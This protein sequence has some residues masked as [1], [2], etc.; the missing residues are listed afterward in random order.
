[1][2]LTPEQH[3]LVEENYPLAKYLARLVWVK[4]QDR[5]DKDELQSIAFQGLVAAAQKF[6]GSRMSQET[7]DNGKA[8]SAFARTKINGAILDWQ[9][10]E[11]HV[12]RSVRS[13]FK[14]LLSAGY[15]PERPGDPSVA[16]LAERTGL[17]AVR[18]RTVLDAVS[19]APLSLDSII[20]SGMNDGD[21]EALLDTEGTALEADGDHAEGAAVVSQI[22]SG[23]VR[24]IRSLPP[25]QQ[26]VIALKY[27]TGSSLI[28][29]STQL[30]LSLTTIAAAHSDA[31]MAIHAAMIR[32]AD[33]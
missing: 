5:L 30:G 18:V 25:L 23:V 20:P 32:S 1:M 10:T 29:I 9:R 28:A 3:R 27:Y 17:S 7:L 13:D 4:N 6:D 2:R 15:D 24:T 31:V 26:T 11:D 16:L 14:G 21:M 19:S 22:T 8:F 12:H 33:H